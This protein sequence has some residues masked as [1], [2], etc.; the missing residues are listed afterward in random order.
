MTVHIDPVGGVLLVVAFAVGY[1][2]YKH[3]RQGLVGK[4]DIVG[5]IVCAT[6]VLTALVL[7]LGGDHSQVPL[8]EPATNEGVLA[9]SP[10]VLSPTPETPTP[11]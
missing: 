5:A 2:V 1:F 9:P 4:G 7:I 8:P 10:S 11:Q 6:S 3:T